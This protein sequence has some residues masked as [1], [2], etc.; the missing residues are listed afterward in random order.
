M[1]F[2]HQLEPQQMQGLPM[3]KHCWEDTKVSD[4]LLPWTCLHGT[5]SLSG[6]HGLAPAWSPYANVA[7]EGP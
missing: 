1:S 5:T 6:A 3:H 7:M 2:E 4:Q